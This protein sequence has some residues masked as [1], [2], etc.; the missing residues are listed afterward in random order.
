MAVRSPGRRERARARQQALRARA[1]RLSERA[2]EERSRHASV[3]AIFDVVDRDAEVGGGIIAGA[4]AYRLFFWSL[5]FALVLVAGLGVAADANSTSPEKA[6]DALGVAG[7]ISNSVASAASSSTRWYALLVGVPLVL[8]ATRSLLRVMIGTHRLVWVDLRTRAPKPTPVATV[9]L[10][11]LI[12]GFFAVTVAAGAARAA[13][14]GPGVLVSLILVAPYAGFWLL[15]SM[16]LPHAVAGWTDLI[17][18]ALL[19]A[20]GIE[21]VQLVSAYVLAPYSIE[22]AG[23]YGAL[24]TAA[25]LLLGLFLVARLM[26]AAAVLNAALW[27]R[28]GARRGERSTE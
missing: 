2:Q 27:E 7:L 13:S 19:F 11:V 26:V 14:P 22:K 4:L 8:F 17:P 16:R 18:G 1:E 3:D 6:A 5:P 12:L 23:T 9:R 28:R 25:A 24:G 15:V 20:V 21:I 10:L